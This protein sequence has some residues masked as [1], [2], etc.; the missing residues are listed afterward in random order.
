MTEHGEQ[1]ALA[2]HL[3]YARDAP[4]GDEIVIFAEGR[5]D[6][7]WPTLVRDLFGPQPEDALLVFGAP[8]QKA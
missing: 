8:D 6:V 2:G 3:Q 7:A 4:W 5:V 1:G